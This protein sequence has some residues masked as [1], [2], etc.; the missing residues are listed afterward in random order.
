MSEHVQALA[1]AAQA[2]Y[3][4]FKLRQE[5]SEV[6]SI[7]A[8]HTE[9]LTLCMTKGDMRRASDIRRNIRTVERELQLIDRMVEALDDRFP[10][11]AAAIS[12]PVR[13]RA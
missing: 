6:A 5:R 7:L 3:F 11:E 10:D 9:S 1:D 4:R 12:G 2:D 8:K 13:R